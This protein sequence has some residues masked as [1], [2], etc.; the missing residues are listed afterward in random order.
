[1]WH[2]CRCFLNALIPSGFIL[3]LYQ[4]KNIFT[5]FKNQ[6]FLCIVMLYHY[7]FPRISEV[8][9]REEIN[10]NIPYFLLYHCFHLKL[11]DCKSC[12]AFI[13]LKYISKSL[14]VFS[15]VPAGNRIVFL[16]LIEINKF[17]RMTVTLV[18]ILTI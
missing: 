9:L 5:L 14:K 6:V 18:T 12:W 15:G 10:V 13:K 11:S 16:I 3:R 2:P 4:K 17:D 8:F 1:M 7:F